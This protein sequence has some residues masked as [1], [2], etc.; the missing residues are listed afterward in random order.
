MHYFAVLM[1]VFLFGCFSSFVFEVFNICLYLTLITL[2]FFFKIIIFRRK[3]IVNLKIFLIIVAFSIG[4]VMGVVHDYVIFKDVKPLY[5][6]VI[7]LEGNVVETGKNKFLIETEYGDFTAYCYFLVPETGNIAEVTGL[8]EG[9]PVAAYRGG[10]DSRLYNALKG[11]LGTITCEDVKITGNTEK[12]YVRTWINSIKGVLEK[13]IMNFRNNSVTAGFIVALLTGNTEYLDYDVKQ[14]FSLTGISHLTAVSGLH[15]GIFL[16]FFAV[17]LKG[18]GKNRFMR[19]FF[20]LI[21][22]IF[23]IIL[24]GERASVFRAGIMSVMSYM[25]LSLKRRSDSLINLMT[26]GF[27]ICVAN[28]YYI[29]NPGFLMSFVATLSIVMFAGYFKR[30]FIA[31]PMIVWLFMTPVSVYYYNIFSIET[32]IVNIIAVPLTPFVILF[33]YAGCVVDWFANISYAFAEVILNVADFFASVD[34]LHI[35]VPCTQLYQFVIWVMLIVAAY[36]VLEKKT[37]S[38]ALCI[39]AFSVCVFVNANYITAEQDE[40]VC[41]VKFINSGGFNMHHVK[42]AFDRNVLID[43]GAYGADYALKNGISEFYAVVISDNDKSRIKGLEELCDTCDVGYVILPDKYRKDNLKLE[44]S[45]VLYYNQYNRNFEVDGIEFRFTERGG[46]KCLLVEICNEV[47]AI[48]DAE[49]VSEIGS[50]TVISTSEKAEDVKQAVDKNMAEYYI[51]PS[52]RNGS[53]ECANKFITAKTGEIQMIFS[54]G[55]EPVLNVY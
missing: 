26:A 41:S 38:N 1:L 25:V 6:T 52:Y 4:M 30:Q 10:F 51:H 34:F 9:Y 11:N 22:V 8:L 47:I 27:L 46:Q 2:A 32:V 18:F 49:R 55:A 31:V 14:D 39:I 42:T 3:S 37:V 40:G 7:R 35:S 17:F 23:Y 50:Y 20:V 29:V 15:V 48:T 33:G 13:R 54:N 21:L 53:Y 28:P 16:S 5:G 44:K 45:R 19:A 36:I 12:Q 43:C 24:V